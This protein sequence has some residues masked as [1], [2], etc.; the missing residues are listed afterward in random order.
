MKRLLCI[1]A[2]FGLA[3]CATEQKLRDHLQTW[4]GHSENQLIAQWGPPQNSYETSDTKFLTYDNDRTVIMPGT[5]P[6]YTTTFYGDTAYTTAIGG[7]DPYAL[8]LNGNYPFCKASTIY[9]I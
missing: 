1:V 6:T 7:T 5:S 8:N 9:S 2:L 4:L 3:A